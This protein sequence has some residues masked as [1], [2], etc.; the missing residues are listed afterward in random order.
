MLARVGRDTDG[1]DIDIIILR[2]LLI[3]YD[4]EVRMLNSPADVPARQWI[5]CAVY[6]QYD[7]LE[8]E[9]SEA[10]VAKALAAADPSRVR[11]LFR[12]VVPV[13]FVS[14]K[15]TPKG[16]R[17]RVGGNRSGHRGSIC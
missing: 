4:A 11:V 6:L 10:A 9:K 7:R 14:G 5:E 1:E 13:L 17:K 3:Q 8:R 16:R 12:Y 15:R 2:G